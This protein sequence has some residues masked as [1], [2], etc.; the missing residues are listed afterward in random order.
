ME[1]FYRS[2]AAGSFGGDA[3]EDVVYEPKEEGKGDG[4][5]EGRE[6]HGAWG[7]DVDHFGKNE[8]EEKQ[9]KCSELMKIWG[10]GLSVLD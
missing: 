1:I 6:D 2:G 10:G 3:V 4:E 5:G 8:E 9:E 7:I